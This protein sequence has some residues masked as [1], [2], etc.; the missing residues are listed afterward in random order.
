M[1]DETSG[2]AIE[3]FF[4]LKL[5]MYSFLADDNSEHKKLKG[6]NRN[7]VATISQNEYKDAL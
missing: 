4:G 2:V 7:V 3:E 1:N 6:V 5:K